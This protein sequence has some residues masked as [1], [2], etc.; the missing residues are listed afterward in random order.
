[1]VFQEMIALPASIFLKEKSICFQA[2]IASSTF[3]NVLEVVEKKFAV[4]K[5]FLC[6][7]NKSKQKSVESARF[8]K[9]NVK[10]KIKL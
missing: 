3:L 8:E 4:L 10:M 2:K 6:N 1:M 5:H 7:F 9:S